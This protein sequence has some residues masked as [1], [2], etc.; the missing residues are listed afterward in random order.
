MLLAEAPSID[1][2]VVVLVLLVFLLL[3]AAAVGIVLWTLVAGYRW[4][5]DR[6]RRRMRAVW[7]AGMALETFAV[8][9]AFVGGEP[10]AIAGTLA[11]LAS[12]ALSP[13]IGGRRRLRRIDDR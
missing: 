4:G 10:G 8:L 6:A 12:S 1:P 11:V 2:G 9:L 7:T 3:V 5:A 13:L